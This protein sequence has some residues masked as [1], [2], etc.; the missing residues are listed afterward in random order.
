LRIDFV[1]PLVQFISHVRIMYSG[2]IDHCATMNALPA[3]PEP[4]LPSIQCVRAAIIARHST[5]DVRHTIVVSGRP[6]VRD[7]RCIT[8]ASA[9]IPTG[10]HAYTAFVATG[11]MPSSCQK[12]RAKKRT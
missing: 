12:K 7:T 11:D 10:P 2:G 1:N 9:A 3:A 8:K 4:P 5:D 6:A